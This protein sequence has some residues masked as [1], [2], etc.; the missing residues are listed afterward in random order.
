LVKLMGTPPG[1]IDE[2]TSGGIWISNEY[3]IPVRLVLEARGEGMKE[4]GS[5]LRLLDINASDIVV[6]EPT[7]AQTATSAAG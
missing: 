7:S 5:L 3:G 2:S 4:D 6:D 1:E